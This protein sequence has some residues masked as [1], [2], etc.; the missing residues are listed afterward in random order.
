MG[1]YEV[2]EFFRIN[3]RER[4]GLM[5]LA[6]LLVLYVIFMQVSDKLIDPPGETPTLAELSAMADS[7]KKATFQEK[8]DEL[9]E[10]RAEKSTRMEVSKN[11]IDPNSADEAEWKALGLKGY[12]VNAIEK[13][14]KASGGFRSYEDFRKLRVIDDS[15][16]KRIKPY[17]I[18][19]NSQGATSRAGW[20]STGS[21]DREDEVD[22]GYTPGKRDSAYGG[23]ASYFYNAVAYRKPIDI[24]RADTSQLKQ[25]YG[26]G[27][28]SAKVM[29]Q[30]REKLGGYVSF[31]QLLEL[32]YMTKGR[33]DSLYPRLD[34]DPT[35]IRK[36][37]IN[38]NTAE[39]LA[40]HPYLT[41]SQANAIVAFRMR[42]GKFNR[43]DQLV[44]HK[45]IPDSILMRLEPYLQLD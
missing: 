27:S 29:V 34:L 12:Q 17:L 20:S 38:S 40:S 26:I 5:V 7:L 8:D 22:Y 21:W 1:W 2:K 10:K 4:H 31:M 14:A 23:S 33:L 6:C 24:N 9:D 42:N 28:W 45:L 16:H 11:S 36:L 30:Y 43:A 18:F 13:Y 35:E 19:R 32:P 41:F 25:V 3:R 15:T 39:F 37:D 44:E